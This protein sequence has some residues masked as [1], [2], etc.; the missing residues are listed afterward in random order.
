MINVFKFFKD[1][2]KVFIKI[3]KIFNINLIEIVFFYFDFLSEELD[4]IKESVIIYFIIILLIMVVYVLIFFVIF[5]CNN[6]V[7]WMNLVFV[8]IFV[9][10]LF[11]VFFFGLVMMCGLEFMIVVGVIFFFIIGKLNICIF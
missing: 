3:M 2:V 10:L 6:V 8:G 11:I 7:N 1:W 9:F 5:N 4:N